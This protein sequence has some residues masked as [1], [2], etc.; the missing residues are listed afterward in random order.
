MKIYGIVLF[1][2][3]ESSHLEFGLGV[4]RGRYK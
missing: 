1:I 2:D 3:A 4:E